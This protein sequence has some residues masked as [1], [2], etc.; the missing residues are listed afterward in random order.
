M[1]DSH[2][3]PKDDGAKD[4]SSRVAGMPTI[5]ELR[6]RVLARSLKKEKSGTDK[7]DRSK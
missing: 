4:A 1:D 2:I 5:A 7:K 3:P 6:R